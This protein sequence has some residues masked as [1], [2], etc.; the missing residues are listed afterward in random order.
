MS[1]ARTFA[2]GLSMSI[3]TVL[4]VISRSR[5][6]VPALASPRPRR[7]PRPRSPVSRQRGC[8]HRIRQ[9]DDCASGAHV[10]RGLLIDD[11]GGPLV[12]PAQ[13]VELVDPNLP[14]AGWGDRTEHGVDEGVNCSEQLYRLSEESFD[15]QV[16][17]DVGADGNRG[18]VA[19]EYGLDDQLRLLLVLGVAD[20]DGVAEAR[21]PVGRLS[22]EAARPARDDDDASGGDF[23]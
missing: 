21:E 2:G 16:V 5:I 8:H 12:R 14:H 10:T 18:A 11:K 4:T 22:A 20:D 17:V 7:P 6:Q 19:V 13:R 15:V 1:A 9:I 23:A 3:D